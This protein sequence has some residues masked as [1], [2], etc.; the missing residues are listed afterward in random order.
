MHRPLSAGPVSASAE[1]YMPFPCEKLGELGI[2]CRQSLFMHTPRISKTLLDHPIY[3][4][5]A[6]T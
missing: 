1:D 2:N 6:N 5:M 4:G 3:T